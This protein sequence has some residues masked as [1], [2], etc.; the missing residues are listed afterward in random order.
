[1]RTYPGISCVVFAVILERKTFKIRQ[2]SIK[3]V[4]SHLNNCRNCRRGSREGDFE[5]GQYV[6]LYISFEEVMSFD[7]KRC[8]VPCWSSDIMLKIIF[9]IK[10]INVL[11]YFPVHPLRK[12]GWGP[13]FARL[14]KNDFFKKFR[15]N[16]ICGSGKDY[17]SNRQCTTVTTTPQPSWKKVTHLNYGLSKDGLL[18]FPSNGSVEISKCEKVTTV[19]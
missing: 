9:I 18:Q 13:S 16:W 6:F 2:C 12:S 3:R 15:W 8:F 10:V 1:M 17:F 14:I 4:T 7:F 19:N 11:H 5:S